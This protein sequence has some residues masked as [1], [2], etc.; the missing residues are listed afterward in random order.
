MALYDKQMT[1]NCNPVC[2]FMN[3]LAVIDQAYILNGQYG[4][5]LEVIE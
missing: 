2:S 5:F 4:L 3:R 1:A